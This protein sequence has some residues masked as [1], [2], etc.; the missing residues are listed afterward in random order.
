M[1]TSTMKL[2][3]CIALALT[4]FAWLALPAPIAWGQDAYKMPP[5]DITAI[6]DAEPPPS[7]S[8]SPDGT[9]MLLIERDAM[10]PVADLARRM[11]R[12][13]GLRIDPA[14]N[15]RYTTNYAKGLKLES[16]DGTLKTALQPPEGGRIGT[17]SW[18][19]DSKRIAYTLVGD[20]G[21]SLWVVEIADIAKTTRVT[22]RLNAISGGFAWLPDQSG[23]LIREVPADRG[24]EPAAP[25]VPTGPTIQ[26]TSGDKSPLRT[27]QDLLSN[28][29]DA[30]LL[31]YYTTAQIV[32]YDFQ[33]GAHRKIGQPAI[34][35][36]AG[37]SPD[38][39]HLL[40]TRVKRP[41]SYLHPYYQ[42]PESIE[43]WD[44][45]GKLEYEVADVP[46]AEG[47]PIGGVRTGRRDVSWK[48]SEPAT[49]IW[50]EALDGG[51]PKREAAHRDKWMA[52]AAP[53]D[54][55]PR[56]LLRTEQRARGLAFF[57]ASN[58]VVATD[59]DR[60]R[61][62][63]RSMLYDL[64]SPS[65]EPVVLDDR[66]VRDRY[67]DPGRIVME[68]DA[69]GRAI[70][71]QRGDWIYRT[72]SGASPD[73]LLPFLDRQNL[74]TGATERLWR[75][76]TGAYESVVDVLPD[77][78]GKPASF[79]TRHET[80]DSPPNYHLRRITGEEIRN[81]TDFPDPTPQIRGIKKKLV[82]YERS[83]GV[84]LSAT[85]YLPADYEEGTRLPLLVWAY[86]REF[87]DPSTAGQVG[88][89]PWRFTRIRG[90]SH[91]SFLT[92]G[93][94]IMDGATIP[95]IGDPETMNDTF[96]EQLVDAAKA[97]IDK[98]VEM[99]VADR[100]RV[101]VGGHSY[102][103]FMTANLLAHCDLFKAGCARSGAYN[104]TLT[105]FGFQSERRTFWEAPEAY[106]KVSP[107]MH[108]HKINEPMLMIHGE[109]DNN[110]G[111]F[112]MQSR[113]MY[114]AIKGNGGT[115][116]LVMLPYESHG[117]RGRESVLHVLAEMVEWF[118]EHV[119]GAKPVEAG[120]STDR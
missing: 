24:R 67:G 61:R 3:T 43:V 89:S 38:G 59:F 114:Q 68:L 36:G 78:N 32:R 20:E 76:A 2:T 73:G 4:L 72:G 82:T 101:G 42:F 26:E 11:L 55:A 53:F 34:Y 119:K 112:P 113:R 102:G 100:D 97:A 33:S 12:I 56:E 98:A 39:E 30:Q 62:W 9:H 28:E 48:T 17:T 7:V 8:F 60:D 117:Y 74:K 88:T 69:S 83:D 41:F 65:S 66:S 99:G 31:E 46:L 105:P 10:P 63:T 14:A 16:L 79:I 23:L 13:G 40:V 107:F 44:W 75:C 81:L 21:T 45:D 49:L 120:I 58:M 29:Y 37:M 71:M 5:A 104:R 109:V 90:T 15:G 52:L 91:L 54:S 57:E 95:I 111:T 1:K 93:Y 22:D 108:A 27:Y 106:F 50:L 70:A 103:A 87:N 25:K 110:S 115:A 80:P 86:P 94:A 6:V 64:S 35:L 116:R 51:D 84:P 18:S 96:V 118:D 77:D 47:I 92:Q 19:P 85:L